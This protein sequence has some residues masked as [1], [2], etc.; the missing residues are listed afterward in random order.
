MESCNVF[1]DENEIVTFDGVYNCFPQG[2]ARDKETIGV[3]LRACIGMQCF[4]NEQTREFS[5]ANF[6]APPYAKASGPPH[7]ILKYVLAVSDG[8]VHAGSGQ[9]V[10]STSNTDFIY[11]NFNI[12]RW[13]GYVKKG[14]ILGTVKLS[15]DP[16]TGMNEVGYGVSL[17]GYSNGKVIDIAS[18][19]RNVPH[20]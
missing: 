16:I 14:M 5:G 13:S 2:I 19:I 7:D 11:S 6:Y 15:Q 20:L 8:T 12:V 4:Y 3:P 1:F 17:T 9:L 18:M 10:L